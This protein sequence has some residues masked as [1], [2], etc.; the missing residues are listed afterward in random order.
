MMEGHPY[1]VWSRRDFPRSG[2]SRRVRNGHGRLTQRTR[3]PF[4]TCESASGEH[5]PSSSVKFH[6]RE[7]WRYSPVVSKTNPSAEA[8]PCRAARD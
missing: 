3:V 8:P 4:G 2:I 5:D 6:A 7:V 1:I